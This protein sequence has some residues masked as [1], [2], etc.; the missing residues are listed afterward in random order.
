MAVTILV[1][2][3]YLLYPI[4]LLLLMSFNTAQ[5]VL[6]GPAKWGISNWITA[7]DHPQLLR[8]I[9]NT[10]LLWFLVATISFPIAIVISLILARTRIPFTYG[11]EYMF[12]IAYMFP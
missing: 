4:V 7:W 11:L 9:G 8:S 5:D 1:L 3:F 6:V 12:W 2:G 10:F